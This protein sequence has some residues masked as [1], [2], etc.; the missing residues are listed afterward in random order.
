[1]TT[2]TRTRTAI[3]T[4][5]LAVT[6]PLA[7]ASCSTDSAPTATDAAAGVGATWGDC[8]RDAGFDVQDPPD[9]MLERGTITMPEGVDQQSWDQAAS[10]C[11]ALAGVERADTADQ[12][13]WA[14]Q[15]DQVASCIRDHGYDDFPEQEPGSIGVDREAYPRAKEPEFEQTFQDCLAE[16]AP[17]T[18]T[19][20]AG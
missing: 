10:K 6:L 13:K 4:L 19:Q 3:A 20:D 9:D 11:S 17:D 1:M 16:Y 5:V 7:L 18:K 12:Q 14:R 15:Y 2:T 8:V